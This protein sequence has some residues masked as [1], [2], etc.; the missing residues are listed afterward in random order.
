MHFIAMS[1][2]NNVNNNNNEIVQ[3]LIS[4]LVQAVNFKLALSTHGS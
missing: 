3:V 4:R 1:Y 2:Q